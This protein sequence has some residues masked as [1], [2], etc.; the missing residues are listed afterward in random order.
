MLGAQSMSQS[1]LDQMKDIDPI[2]I[3]KENLQYLELDMASI[4]S[5]L[6]QDIL[7][8]AFDEEIKDM[9][10][11][12]YLP[13]D[14][15]NANCLVDQIELAFA[16]YQDMREEV[17]QE[18]LLKAMRVGNLDLFESILGMGADNVSHLRRDDTF[19]KF[20]YELTS[21]LTSPEFF[22]TFIR[23]CDVDTEL[24]RVLL[25]RMN[26]FNRAI[27]QSFV[28]T[29]CI[30]LTKDEVEQSDLMN[31]QLPEDVRRAFENAAPVQEEGYLKMGQIYAHKD[32]NP[33]S[34]MQVEHLNKFDVVYSIASP[35]HQ[36]VALSPDMEIGNIFIVFQKLLAQNPGIQ[37]SVF[38][39]IPEA[40][41]AF[42]LKSPGMEGPFFSV[43]SRDE[44]GVC[45]MVPEMM[46]RLYTNMSQQKPDEML[47]CR[48]PVD[49]SMF[50]FGLPDN[51]AKA[52]GYQLLIDTQAMFYGLPANKEE[53]LSS[54]KSFLD[55]KHVQIH[56]DVAFALLKDAPK[57]QSG[58]QF[59]LTF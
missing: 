29:C 15:L 35:V 17:L 28:D 43:M 57:G 54:F 7:D 44:E 32:V 22:K 36:K 13:L 16:D 19:Y 12:V 3:A 50:F 2:L 25:E 45:Q 38:V 58:H 53:I 47:Y 33:D 4:D 27:H 52:T 37:F 23:A 59:N 10:R 31:I 9:V 40:G 46:S 24:S 41:H 26:V 56:V 14:G 51:Y 1:F 49:N 5:V 48:F 18:F 34:T 6:L 39:Y 30:H 11:S 8:D 55:V 20:I 42:V 21:P